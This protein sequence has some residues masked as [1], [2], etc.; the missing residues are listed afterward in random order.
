MVHI[1]KMIIS[2]GFFF[3]FFKILIFWI[4]RV[5]KVQKMLYNDKRFCSSHFI[6]QEPYIIWLSFMVHICKMMI[7]PVNFFIFR[8][9]DFEGFQENKGGKIAK[10]DLKLRISVCFAPYLRNCRSYHRDLIM[11]STGVFFF[12]S[13]KYI[14]LNIE[15]FQVKCQK[16]I[17]RCGPP[18]SH[19]CDFF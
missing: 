8:N 9:V 13:S 15:I 19:V 10:N 3:Q 14:I 7:S 17:L 1:C 6:L 5:G 4:L 16:G 18:S 12:L 2:P 11:I